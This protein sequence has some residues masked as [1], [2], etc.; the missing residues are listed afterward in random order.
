[1]DC[2]EMNE[3]NGIIKIVLRTQRVVNTRRCSSVIILSVN[4]GN[5]RLGIFNQ[6][7]FN[8]LLWKTH[9]KSKASRIYF[10]RI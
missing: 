6:I 10:N 7:N 5:Q 2:I 3:P 4:A 1:M 9:K 8:E